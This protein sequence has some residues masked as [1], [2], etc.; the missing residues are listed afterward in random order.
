MILNYI[1]SNENI[2]TLL[3]SFVP[4]INIFLGNKV[5]LPSV[6]SILYIYILFL[7]NVKYR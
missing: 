2:L 7:G 4:S 3:N 1:F 6:Y 5:Q